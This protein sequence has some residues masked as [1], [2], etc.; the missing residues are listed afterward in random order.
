MS[1][2]T[3]YI[4]KI[5]GGTDKLR[6]AAGDFIELVL[7]PW[8]PQRTEKKTVIHIIVFRNEWKTGGL[9]TPESVCEEVATVFPGLHI[10]LKSQSEYGYGHSGEWFTR[11]KPPKDFLEILADRVLH[12][13]LTEIEGP[14][15]RVPWLAAL[16]H[17]VSS[18]PECCTKIEAIGLAMIE[19]QSAMGKKTLVLDAMSDRTVKGAERLETMTKW[20]FHPLFVHESRKIGKI[21]KPSLWWKPSDYEEDWAES[22]TYNLNV[23]MQTFE[24]KT[25][26]FAIGSPIMPVS[27]KEARFLEKQ[28]RMALN[29]HEIFPFYVR[30]S[31]GIGN[32]VGELQKRGTSFV[33]LHSMDY[34]PHR[35]SFKCEARKSM[36]LAERLQGGT[37]Y[38]IVEEEKSFSKT[39]VIDVSLADGCLAASASH[40]FVS[41]SVYV[42]SQSCYKNALT[43]ISL[44][45]GSVLWRSD[46]VFDFCEAILVS[47]DSRLFAVTR[48]RNHPQVLSCFEGKAGAELWQTELSKDG[49]IK[50]AASQDTI[51]ILSHDSEARSL[52]L[53]RASN[54]EKIAEQLLEYELSQDAIAM[55]DVCVYVA[56]E[57]WVAAFTHRGEEVWKVFLPAGRPLGISLTGKNTLLVSRSERGIAC[58]HCEDGSIAW[59]ASDDPVG[60]PCVVGA[61]D[62]AYYASGSTCAARHIRD[63]SLAWKNDLENE[64]NNAS[65]I[66]VTE[67]AVIIDDQQGFV[68]WIDVSSGKTLS[69]LALQVDQSIMAGDGNLICTGYPLFSKT[70]WPNQLMCVAMNVGQPTGPWPMPR[71]GAGQNCYLKNKEQNGCEQ[72]VMAW[73]AGEDMTSRLA[74]FSYSCNADRDQEAQVQGIV[75][76]HE[77]IAQSRVWV[78]PSIGPARAGIARGAQWRLVIAYEG[79]E[80]LAKSLLGANGKESIE[81]LLTHLT[82]K[83]SLGIFE[84]LLPPQI[85]EGSLNEWLK[86][87]TQCDV[88]HFLKME[89]VDLSR[90]DAW[91]GRQE[92]IRTWNNAILLSKAFHSATVHGALLPAIINEWNLIDAVKRLTDVIFVV[93]DAIFTCVDQ[94]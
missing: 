25:C 71:Q 79:F 5:K 84:M 47:N 76:G 33:W 46:M 10:S 73:K 14:E 9:L 92:P 56:S 23:N 11:G 74:L 81:V 69:F 24:G 2:D 45:D 80:V 75:R 93:D 38:E 68:K 20:A 41:T 48:N 65:V 43:G 83:L 55:D 62:V 63:G 85:E 6:R 78:K 12:R 59:I 86:N 13:I 26:F 19:A 28:I 89:S 16:F 27:R 64:V 34:K 7:Y 32:V 39:R 61:G 54:G 58:L 82:D 66:A 53:W 31:K 8:R 4:I 87:E 30:T 35:M 72:F 44:E 77:L 94:A 36:H 57:S 49:R 18:T 60:S 29:G 17:W 88:L 51:A 91:L 15:N 70:G 1:N 37:M 21:G 67:L 22:K 50:L 52:F 42:K 90:F 3:D 40:I